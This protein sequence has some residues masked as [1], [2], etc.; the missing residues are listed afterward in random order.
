MYDK[1]ENDLD[2][3]NF[4]QTNS[5]C[6]SIMLGGAYV[7]LDVTTTSIKTL[8]KSLFIKKWAFMIKNV[9]A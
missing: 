1:I 5:D 7:N 9:K 3:V 2:R 6:D 4:C 8:T